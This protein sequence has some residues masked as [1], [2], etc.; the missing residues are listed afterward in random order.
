MPCGGSTTTTARVSYVQLASEGR[1]YSAD[2]VE[3]NSFPRRN[4]CV[5]SSSYGT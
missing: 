1:Y 3:R 2:A 5:D 4:M